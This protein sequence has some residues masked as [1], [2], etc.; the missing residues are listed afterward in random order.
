MDI[1]AELLKEH[2]RKQA[3]L[4]SIYI[5]TDASRFSELVSILFGNDHRA[6]QRAAWPISICV[7]THP[8]LLTPHFN[9]LLD[10][11]PQKDIHNAVKRNITRLLQFVEIPKRLQGKVYS[12]CID[13]I[14]DPNEFVAVKANAITIAEKIARTEPAL[15]DELRMVAKPLLKDVPPSLRARLRPIFKGL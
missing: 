11:L 1:R 15:M 8:E 10:L 4:I 9:K 12:H 7:E 3:D 14:A 6:V 5:G 2:S 13:L